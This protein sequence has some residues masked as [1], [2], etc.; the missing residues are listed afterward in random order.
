MTVEIQVQITTI[1]AMKNI[2]QISWKQIKEC[3]GIDVLNY[4]NVLREVEQ[5]TNESAFPNGTLWNTEMEQT[6]QQDW[7]NLINC[8]LFVFDI[9][10]A[11]S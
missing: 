7:F 5:Q 8:S 2:S 3:L 1:R 11:K 9:V 6:L 10:N 4:D